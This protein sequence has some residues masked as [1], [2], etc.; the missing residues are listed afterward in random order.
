MALTRS[1]KV[2]NGSDSVP[3]TDVT[4]RTDWPQTE[5][6]GMANLG[7]AAAGQWLMRDEGGT[8]PDFVGAGELLDAHNVIVAT[9]GSN[10]LFRGR[11]AADDHFRGRQKAGR[12]KEITF[13]LEDANSHLRGIVVHNWVR[14]AETDGARAQ[15][16][17]ASYLSGNY[18]TTTNLNGSNLIVMSSNLISLPAKTYSGVTP[19]EIMSELA[20]NG[21]KEMFVS[22]DNELAYFGHDYT[23]YASQLRISD[24]LADANST[25][26][27]PWTP[28]GSEFG[29]QKLSALRVYYGTDVT[30]STIRLT[31]SIAPRYDYWEDIFWDSESVTSA[32][33]AARAQ[34]MLDYRSTDDVSYSC[35]IGPMSGDEIYKI[36]P[37]HSIS[38]KS[39]A[40][41]GGRNPNGTY[42]G[43][44]FLT[45]RIRDLRWTMPNEDQ[46][47]AHL[48]LERPKR[49]GPPSSGS[50]A[51]TTASKPA[52]PTSSPSVGST[53]L[54]RWSFT[55]NDYDDASG[56]YQTSFIRSGNPAGFINPG[57]GSGGY[58]YITASGSAGNADNIPATPGTTY[59]FSGR[60]FFKSSPEVC[61]IRVQWRLGSTVLRN[62]TIVDGAAYGAGTIYTFSGVVSAPATT[63]NVQILAIGVMK[64]AVDD[65]VMSIAAAAAE[66]SPPYALA[67]PGV[68]PYYARSDDPRFDADNQHLS[69]LLSRRMT[70]NS[71]VALVEGDVVVPDLTLA[72]AVTRTTT[73]NLTASM[74]GVAVEGA[75][76]SAEVVVMWSGS[77]S[78][79]TCTDTTPTAGDYL[80]TS[81][82]AGSSQT[83]ATRSAGAVGR[84]IAVDGTNQALVLWW[85]NPDTTTGSVAT[86]AIWDAAGDLAVGTGADTAARLAIGA[87]NTHLISDGATALWRSNT[88]G[89][90]DAMSALASGTGDVTTT[91]S[92][93][94]VTGATLSLEAGTYIIHGTFDV[95]VN[96]AL[97]DRTFEGHL[98]VVSADENDYAQLNA[99]GLVNVRATLGQSWR[100]VGSNTFTVKLRAQ[101]SGG[102]AGDFT[103]KSTNTTLTAYRAGGGT[104]HGG[105]TTTTPTWTTTGTA[106]AIGN[107][108]LTARYNKIDDNTYL[109]YLNFTAG[110]TTTFGTGTWAFS[111]PF[112]S[113]G[114]RNQILSGWILDS[115]TDN[116]VAAGNIVA[117]DTKIVQITPEGGNVVTNTVPM[118]WATGDQLTL[119]GI[120]EV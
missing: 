53:E 112:T 91:S 90:V 48:Q 4:D 81:T 76:A 44:S 66:A 10:T 108:T 116:K 74:V 120:I 73:A 6:A 17:V 27:A 26:W 30:Q 62:D 46:Y 107:G 42:T 111:L 12:A 36:K 33:A 102:T 18:R 100:V 82:T 70:N 45:T 22:V 93:T 47:I 28:R 77:V 43:D 38:Y 55:T 23:G 96:N 32:Q 68:S 117:S 64:I 104:V 85:G 57:F 83:S 9:V 65:L 84:I 75:A 86:D 11:I 110:S 52:P 67:N 114:S 109:Y 2:Y 25:T 35:A 92:L 24:A 16:L 118:T 59:D 51:L 88:F 8:I 71:G 19:F 50:Q 5:L 89:V 49:T 72:G 119:S 29:R 94:D 115:G 79:V 80:S 31:N 106:P 37:G 98:Q 3:V 40:S 20:S 41:R 95:L 61:N 58:G 39:R 113:V 87:S 21:D 13:T 14:P 56:T 97:N 1:L 15:G 99:P 69:Y 105:W 60:V 7:E 54:H 63:D 101:H 78:S 34:K 103:V